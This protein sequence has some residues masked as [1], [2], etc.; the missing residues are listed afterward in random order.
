[1]KTSRR[2]FLTTGTSAIALSAGI[3][4]A[5]A[6]AKGLL[7]TKKEAATPSAFDPASDAFE[8]ISSLNIIDFEREIGTY[9]RFVSALHDESG[10]E[11]VDVSELKQPGNT[12]HLIYHTAGFTLLFKPR[13]GHPVFQDVVLV[14]HERLGSFHM[15][16]SPVRTS[17]KD[18]T[19]VFQAVVN[20][21]V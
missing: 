17:R 7:D 12:E 11:L 3:L 2:S 5:P 15:L 20:R 6:A 1:M 4:S 9:F 8:A 18:K 19:I 21:F 13:S 16:V 10:G 14:Q